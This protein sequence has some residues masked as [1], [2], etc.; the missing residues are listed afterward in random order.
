[1]KFGIFSYFRTSKTKNNCPC[2]IILANRR[3]HPLNR[4]SASS[5]DQ[6]MN[7]TQIKISFGLHTKR[8]HLFTG[9]IIG[10][11]T[12]THYSNPIKM[13]PPQTW[14]RPNKEKSLFVLNL[15]E[16]EATNSSLNARSFGALFIGWMKRLCAKSMRYRAMSSC[17]NEWKKKQ[18]CY[19][20]F[21]CCISIENKESRL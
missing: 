20:L 21:L 6:V 18:V 5:K 2:I 7:P 11:H 17:K 15:P 8:T 4:R 14:S 12:N 10:L 19:Q 16:N 13:L 1:M 3:T 9:G